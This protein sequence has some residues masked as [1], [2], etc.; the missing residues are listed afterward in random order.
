MQIFHIDRRKPSD[1]DPVYIID[2]VKELQKKLIVVRNDDLISR[3][4]QAN[5]TLNFSMH[6]RASFA[7]RGE[8]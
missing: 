1:L 5:A 7:T 4:C 6:L 8:S 2:A 3:E